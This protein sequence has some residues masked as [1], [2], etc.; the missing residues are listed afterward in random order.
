LGGNISWA[1]D[2]SDRGEIVGA[3]GTFG[4]FSSFVHTGSGMV[5]LN[6]LVTSP[7]GRLVD[8]LS[9]SPNGIIVAQISRNTLAILTPGAGTSTPAGS[10]VVV[11]APT[12]LPNGGTT[13]VSVTFSDVDVGGTTTVT[14]APAGPP[15]PSGFKLTSPPVYYDVQTSASFTGTVRVCLGWT[16]GQVAHEPGVTIQ[17]YEN[18]HWV[19]ITDAS[20]RD[21]VNNR[22]CGTATSLSPFALM[23][24]KYPFAGFYQPVDNAPTVNAVKAGAA[25]PIKFSLGGDF[26]LSIFASGYPKAQLMQCAT[27]EA[28]DTI[29]ETVSVGGSSLSYDT[30]TGLYTYVWKTDK[31]WANSCREL[32]VKLNDGE[33]YTARFTLRK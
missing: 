29:E 20:S 4:S 14:T 7:P 6:T 26:G 10:D 13:A 30:T 32:Q 5:D 24:V 12:V 19:N 16:E 25:V 8:S 28:I 22:V 17:H 27:G 2:V 11:N 15:P 33:M 31:A 21:T 23:E 3:T 18:G 1:N 9:I